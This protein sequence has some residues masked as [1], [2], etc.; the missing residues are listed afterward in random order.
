MKNKMLQLPKLKELIKAKQ[1]IAKL[2]VTNADVAYLLHDEKNEIREIRPVINRK[3]S[4]REQLT[5]LFND[6]N[7]QLKRIY[8]QQ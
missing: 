6:K 7:K 4:A 1:Q 3:A 8:K 5:T 2:Q